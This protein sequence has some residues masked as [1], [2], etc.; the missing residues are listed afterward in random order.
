MQLA[1]A[2][3]NGQSFLLAQN[4]DPRAPESGLT[5]SRLIEILHSAAANETSSC[6]N[7]LLILDV[8][9]P[10]H[11]LLTGSLVVACEG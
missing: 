6:E 5:I 11:N 9:N 7:V 3:A 2:S 8:C 10:T 4:S 1:S